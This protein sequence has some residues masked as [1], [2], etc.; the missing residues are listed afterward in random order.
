MLG[1]E[2]PLDGMSGEASQRR[3]HGNRGRWESELCGN[4][5]EISQAETLGRECVWHVPGKRSEGAVR[6]GMESMSERGAIEG[7]RDATAVS[8]L[9]GGLLQ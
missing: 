3:Q 9:G 8:A 1:S 6:R 5:G 4:P 2:T 7:A